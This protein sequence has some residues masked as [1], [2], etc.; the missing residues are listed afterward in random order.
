MDRSRDVAL[1]LGEG[2]RAATAGSIAK[3]GESKALENCA[4]RDRLPSEKRRFAGLGRIGKAPWIDPTRPPM[5]R[6]VTAMVWP[7]TVPCWK[8][9]TTVPL[10]PPW[11][12]LR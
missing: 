2:V 7:G 9:P 4:L 8:R 3:R 5:L 12:K 1:L 6:D 11:R 10:P